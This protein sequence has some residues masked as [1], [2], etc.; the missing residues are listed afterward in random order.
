MEESV[1]VM[2]LKLLRALHN[3]NAGLRSLTDVSIRGMPS[4]CRSARIPTRAGASIIWRLLSALQV[5]CVRASFEGFEFD[6]D[7]FT[8]V[9]SGRV[10]A[11]EP[12]VFDVLSLLI[13]HR[14]RV[15]PKEELLDKVWGDR[16]VSESA[17]TSRIKAVRQAVG[18]DGTSQRFV[19]TIRGRG[20]RFIASVTELGNGTESE[21][22]T[23]SE[24][25]PTTMSAPS[26][27]V[28]FL[29]TD[30]A[31]STELW[32]ADRE[33]MSASLQVHDRILRS[34]VEAF[35]DLRA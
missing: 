17:L 11:V 33:A 19:Q 32:A 22:E 27:V 9:R 24:S 20:Y 15:V 23:E 26:G 21:S 35:G 13:L 12:Q 2:L 28:T 25:A 7:Q 10:I 8:L 18:D 14:D 6:T 3:Y 29:F 5:A 30:V 34:G 31:D 1:V 16:F 4:P